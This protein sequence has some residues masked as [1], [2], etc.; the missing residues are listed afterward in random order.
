MEKITKERMEELTETLKEAQ[1][2]IDGKSLIQNNKFLFSYQDKNYSCRMPNQ[3]EQSEADQAQNIYK[4]S[5]IKKEGT[6][7]KKQLIKV[8]KENQDI[9]IAELEKNKLKIQDE[10]QTVYLELAVVPSDDTGK[11]N[12]V[13]KK[14]KAIEEK[15]MQVS[16]EIVEMLAPC[17]EEQT[18]IQYFRYLGYLCTDQKVPEKDEYERTW[19]S[20]EEFENDSTGLSYKCVEGIQTLL[21]SV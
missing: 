20:F 2:N 11:I 3:R 16:I 13:T 17:I 1:L 12:Q 21:L 6:I 5:L 9:D 15:F 4:I 14:Q 8:L 18:K 7:T 10:L 19:K